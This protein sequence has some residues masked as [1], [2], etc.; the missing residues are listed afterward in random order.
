MKQN[1]QLCFR[2]WFT[3]HT[4]ITTIFIFFFCFIFHLIFSDI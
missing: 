2:D 4:V 1:F 3:L